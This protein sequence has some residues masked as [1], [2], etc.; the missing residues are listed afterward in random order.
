MRHVGLPFQMGSCFIR[1]IVT[2]GQARMASQDNIYQ[3]AS[4][5]SVFGNTKTH[6]ETVQRQ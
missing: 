4:L 5:T 2:A 6:E 1:T 3:P